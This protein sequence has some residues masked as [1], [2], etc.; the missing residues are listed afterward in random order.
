MTTNK[1]FPKGQINIINQNGSDQTEPETGLE[2]N[3]HWRDGVPVCAEIFG[4][5]EEH[6]AEIGLEFDGKDLVDYDGVFE[7]PAE[8]AEMLKEAGYRIEL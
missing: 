4:E 1:K 2:V 7:L 6:Y 8:V 3:L 5:R